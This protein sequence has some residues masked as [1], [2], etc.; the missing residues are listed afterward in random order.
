MAETIFPAFL[1]LEHR[2]DSRTQSA[3]L[4]EIDGALTPAERRFQTFS[5]EAQRM[6]DRALSTERSK[7]G[8][9]DLDVAGLHRQAASLEQQ[10]VAA[11]ELALATEMASKEAGDFSQTARLQVAAMQATAREAEQAAASAREYASAQAQVQA[12][13]D[14]T[15]SD[16]TAVTAAT[17]RAGIA[18]DNAAM[19]TAAHR[20]GLQQLGYQLGDV[21]VMYAMGARPAQIFASQIGQVTQAVQMMSGGTSKLASFLGGPW[22]IGI[23][24]GVMALGPLIGKLFETEDALGRVG[25]AA[26]EAMKKVQN[27]VSQVS[28]FTD[29][30]DLNV[31][32]KIK[33]MGDLARANREIAETRA[34]IESL[35]GMPGGADLIQGQTA[36]LSRMTAQK[37]AAEKAIKE[38]D[39]AL[40]TLRLNTEI[41]NKQTAAQGRLDQLDDKPSKPVRSRKSELTAEAKALQQAAK[42]ADSYIASLEQEIARIGATPGQ[43]RQLEVARAREAAATDAQRQRIDELNASREEAISTQAREE[44]ATQ[45]AEALAEFR[46]RTIQPLRDEYELLGL[47]GPAR[48]KAAL[49]L[50]EDAFKADAAAKGIEDVNAAWS[51]YYDWQTRIID[52]GSVLERERQEAQLLAQDLDRLVG[53][54]GN[55]GGVGGILGDVMGFTTGGAVPGPLGALL[56]TVTGTRTNDEG[57]VIARTLGDELRD[58]F[59]ITGVFGETM[60]HAMKGAGIGSLAAASLFGEQSATG[61]AG[62]AIGG[63]LGQA[64]GEALTKG[65]TG[66]LGSAGGPIGAIAGGLIG[67]VLGGV[68]GGGSKTARANVTGMGKSSVAGAD[69]GNY[70]VASGLGSSVQEALRK[71]ADQLDADIG[72]FQVAIGTRGGDFRVN[73]NGTSLKIKNGAVNFGE[74]QAAAIAY[75]LGNA[76][77]DGAIKGLKASEQRLLKAN[78]DI[79]AALQDVLDFRSVFD[80]LKALK[81]PVGSALDDLDDE[82]E[83][84]QDIF[85]QAGASTAEWADLEELYWLERDAIIKDAT[86]RSLGSLRDLMSDLTVGNSALSLRDRKDLAE[87]EY[88]PLA[89]R[90]AAGDATAYDDFAEAARTLLD[91]ERQLS[92]SQGSYFELL[93][94]VKGLTTTALSEGTGLD[95]DGRD[96][97]F[98][99]RPAANDNR[100]VADSVDQLR[101]EI[102]NGT[103]AHLEAVNRN[104]GRLINLASQTGTGWGRPSYDYG[105]LGRF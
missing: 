24:I 96:S 67:G 92:G 103:N 46:S 22:G 43:I 98:G 41:R 64:G 49:A 21:S 48:E 13:L 100:A 27:A 8:S 12:V 34:Q 11:R 36:Y 40:E 102:A 44:A 39:A 71:L 90:V 18:N 88:N 81:D 52:K 2:K 47:V 74:D 1:K 73:P 80:R 10:A 29:A 54:M 7:F 53:A 56:G 104:L 83:H 69:D 19:S 9:L 101:D 42:E 35:A 65:L 105:T 26:Q 94:E 3:F 38:S 97:P 32:A 59:G 70:G 86:E 60:T 25:T 14:R 58:V 75:A 77:A 4:S 23:G 72:S 31:K 68:L 33:A 50:Q 85:K 76:V 93:D 78:S 6:I 87:A 91:I 95:L 15:V 20:A 5:A 82:F 28:E 17:R 89:E 61:Q 55:L 37:Q 51:E 63:A 62:S 66:F 84:L 30:A 79:E 45:S 99:D 57:D 16:V